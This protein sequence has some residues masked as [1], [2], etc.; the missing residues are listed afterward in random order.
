MKYDIYI[1]TKKDME[2]SGGTLLH[3]RCSNDSV[4]LFCK[5]EKINVDDFF[6]GDFMNGFWLEEAM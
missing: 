1:G 6:N 2:E 4:V 5:K 3:S